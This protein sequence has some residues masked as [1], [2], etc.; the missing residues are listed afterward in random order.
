V[1]PHLEYGNPIWGP[2]NKA[3]QKLVERVQRRATRVVTTIRGMPYE[4]RLRALKLPSLQYRR[5]RGDMILLYNLM[6]GNVGLRREEFFEEP[7]MTTTRGHSLKVAKPRAHTRVRRNHL[8]VR[9]VS[10]W[11][12]L[13][14]SVV[15]APSV[16]S[17]K[18]RLD[19]HWQDH[20]YEAP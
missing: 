8:G 7:P 19:E 5:R 1:R 17:F 16:N 15:S 14:E 12:S 2:F 11:N 18:K 13:P 6:H 10:D 20:L 3:D 4:D 9:A